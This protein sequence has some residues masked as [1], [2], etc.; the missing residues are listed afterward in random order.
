MPYRWTKNQIQEETL[1]QSREFDNAL[2]NYVDV[3]N[4]GLDRDNVPQDTITATFVPNSTFS[5][6]K[7]FSGIN[8]SDADLGEDQ[9]YTGGVNPLD[10]KLYGFRYGESPIQGGGGWINA[11]TQNLNTEEGMLEVSWSCSQLINIYWS[12]ENDSGG[13]LDGERVA[14]KH[15][16]WRILV[17]G[18]PVYYSM[19]IYDVMHTSVHKVNV[20]ISKG[21]HTIQV[22]WNVATQKTGDEDQTQVIFNW[23]GGQLVCLN[24]YR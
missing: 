4:G 15:G 22:Q 7:V 18:N 2:G 12:Y 14:L 17:D 6:I 13:S 3:V 9:E 19:D 21:S 20:P 5:S 16:Q 10:R 8:A 1:F 23:W 24:R 11:T